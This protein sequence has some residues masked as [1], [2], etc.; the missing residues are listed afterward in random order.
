MRFTDRALKMTNR[1]SLL[2]GLVVL[3]FLSLPWL[4]SNAAEPLPEDH[5]IFWE[6]RVIGD[7]ILLKNPN[8]TVERIPSVYK[9]YDGLGT[10]WWDDDVRLTY[11]TCSAHN[12]SVAARD[13]YL[14][15]TWMDDRIGLKY[16]AFFKR[17][18]DLGYTWQDE[19]VISDTLQEQQHG[20][21]DIAISTNYL[22][23]VWGYFWKPIWEDGHIYY[24]R[25]L[26]NGGTW[27]DAYYLSSYEMQSKPS[28]ATLSDTV[29]VVF[30][31][32]IERHGNYFPELHFR[33]SHDEGATWTED[34]VIAD[35]YPELID[36]VLRANEEGLHYVFQHKDN[37]DDPG[38]PYRSQ[39]IF[40]T[41]SSDFGETWTDPIIV[42]HQDSIHSQW[43][44]MCVADE[45]TIHVTWFDYKYSPY[46]E[47]GDIFY[48]KTTD[49][50]TDD[51][52][53]WCEIQVLTNAHLARASHITTSDHRL[54]LVWEDERN[55]H[56]N[57]ETYF[58]RSLTRGES[59]GSEERL[60]NAPKE[61]V[62]PV[63][64]E[65]DDTLYVVW[66]D[67]RDDP[68]NRAEEIYFKRGGLQAISPQK[69]SPTE[70]D[71]YL[72]PY[73]NPLNDMTIIKYGIIGSPGPQRASLKIYNIRGRLVRP[74]LDRE[75]VPGEYETLWDGTDSKEMKVSS[76]IYL[77]VLQVEHARLLSRLVYLK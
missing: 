48:T 18:T 70:Y 58:R 36:G 10:T 35:Y 44:S 12:P 13:A 14:H 47:T 49:K 1:L 75:L 67:C 38:N 40:C 31:R 59:W 43:P 60:T 77:C 6:Y 29:Y 64:A 30:T 5:D 52:H 21:P 9:G 24:R 42:S 28:I 27:E 41:H 55:G 3:A 66:A 72:I 63:I 39:E 19:V 71:L 23:A 46:S 2:G 17:S 25:S 15:I 33:K 20:A 57:N 68:T 51:G 32:T 69:S 34:R 61:S 54:Y 7:R 26:D 37:F 74:L 56:N 4:P 8:A 45:G 65:Q 50:S 76:G 22:H 53:L 73:P 11:D 16:K 62:E